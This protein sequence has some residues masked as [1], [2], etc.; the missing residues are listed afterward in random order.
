MAQSSSNFRYE[1]ALSA[2]V[3]FLVGF[4]IATGLHIIIAVRMRIW[5]F[6]PLICGGIRALPLGLSALPTF[7]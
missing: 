1:P 2:A 4:A 5:Y 7:H 6:T 3:I